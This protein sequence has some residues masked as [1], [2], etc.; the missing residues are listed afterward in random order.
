MGVIVDHIKIEG[1][2]FNGREPN[3]QRYGIQLAALDS[4]SARA[5]VALTSRWTAQYSYGRL[6][7]PEALEPGSER[8]QSAS[9][10]YLKPFVGGSWATSAIWGRKHKELEN[11]N[12]NSYL[13]EST[14]NF[15]TR[16]Y[17]F[18]R[19]ELVDKDELFPDDPLRP[20]FRIGGYT[21]GGARDLVE[22]Q[23]WQMSLGA[24]LTLYSK[25]Q[26]LRATYGERPISF[27]V[28][29]RIRPGSASHH[30]H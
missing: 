27:Q 5:S 23:L 14:V 6:E 19:L 10:E 26:S 9:V 2:L 22:T 11:R 24:D 12:L 25:P 30:Q 29:L 28:F 7:H 8:R 21:F 3:E 15:M 17:A 13:L 20:N 1:S 16:N 4:W 18:S